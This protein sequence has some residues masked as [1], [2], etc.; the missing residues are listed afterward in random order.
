MKVLVIGSGGR[1]HA[2]A[3]KLRRSPRVHEIFVAPGNAGTARVGTNVAI[4]AGD[5]PGL[6]KFAEQ[7]DV[8]LTVVGPDNALAGG[9]VD[10]F[11]DAGRRAF[12][13]RQAAAKLES[14]KSFAKDFMVRHGIP[15]AHYA[16]CRS[17]DEA[18]AALG[19][20]SFPVAVKADGL[21]LGKGVVIAQSR[22]EAERVVTEMLEQGRFGEAGRTVVLEEFLVGTECSVHALVDGRSFLLFPTAQDHKQLYEGNRGPNTGGMGSFSPSNK[23]AEPDLVEIRRQILE[24]FL[25][26]IQTDKLVYRGLLFPGLMLTAEGPKVLEFNCRFGDPE[27]QAL[28]P[29]LETDLLDLLEATLE[30]RLDQVTPAWTTQSAV[31]V[32]LASGGYPDRYDTRKPIA[33]LAE[34]EQLEDVVIFHAGT[35]QEDN[36]VLTAGGRVLGV[37][38]LGANLSSARRRAYDAVERIRFDGRY[39]RRDIGLI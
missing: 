19:D 33:G 6:L 29:R 28:V 8:D 17:R 20:F 30:R 13:P 1:E 16:V 36:R 35:Q 39:F 21:A 32:V 26:G 2:L 24:P 4:S 5:F 38:A 15:T 3:W 12:G 11:E 18:R 25:H 31:C 7:Q 14:S 9:V 27:T 37:T 23:L 34:A 10:L 22:P